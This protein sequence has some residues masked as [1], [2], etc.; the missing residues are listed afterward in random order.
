MARD[1]DDRCPECGAI[2]S[3]TPQLAAV[4]WLALPEMRY[5][6]AYVWLLLI[7]FLDVLLTFLVL[8]EWDGHEANPIAHAIIEQMGLVW[9]A[10]FKFA[11]VLLVIIICETVGRRRDRTGRGLSRVAV[12]ISAFPVAYTLALLLRTGPPAF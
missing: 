2:V 3:A 9:A 12:A 1:N 7:S 4:P 11:S 8:Y 6:N 10:L 5:Q